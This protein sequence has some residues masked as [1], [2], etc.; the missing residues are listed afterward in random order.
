MK[1]STLA[2]FGMLWCLGSSAS[3]LTRESKEKA[4][5]ASTPPMSLE[6]IDS[7][8]KLRACLGVSGEPKM[9][10][11]ESTSGR[12]EEWQVLPLVRSMEIELLRESGAP[13]PAR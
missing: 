3:R 5:L 6:A 13:P 12:G 11:K 8:K 2:E 10:S 7:S 1:S 4:L 9:L